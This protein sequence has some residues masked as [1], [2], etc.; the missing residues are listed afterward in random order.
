MSVTKER[1]LAIGLAIVAL[2]ICA[3][4]APAA[5][6]DFSATVA[7]GSVPAG[8]LV[9]MTVT[10]GNLTAQQQLGSANVTPPSGFTAVSVTSLTRPAPATATI[11]GRVVQLRD[12]SLRPQDAVTVALKVS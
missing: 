8:R 5:T 9:D 10:I 11:V 7:P 1:V 2:A 3:T 12:L 6:K 4:G